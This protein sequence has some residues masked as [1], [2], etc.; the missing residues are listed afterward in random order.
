LDGWYILEQS[1]VLA[2]MGPKPLFEIQSS[3]ASVEGTVTTGTV[4]CAVKVGS[5][6]VALVPS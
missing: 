2:S 5:P 1:S 3:D 4:Q 6:A